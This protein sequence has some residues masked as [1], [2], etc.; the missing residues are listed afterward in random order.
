MT[1]RG[2]THAE[3]GGEALVRR[4]EDDVG[5]ELRLVRHHDQRQLDLCRLDFRRQ[6]RQHGVGSRPERWSLADRGGRA[7]AVVGPAV[8]RA[9]RRRGIGWD[10]QPEAEAARLFSDET[11]RGGRGD[12]QMTA[13]GEQLTANVQL[14]LVPQALGGLVRPLGAVPMSAFGRLPRGQTDKATFVVPSRVTEMLLTL[15]GVG[16]SSATTPWA[17]QSLERDP[18]KV[19]SSVTWTSSSCLY[20]GGPLWAD[21]GGGRSGMPG[22]TWTMMGESRIVVS[23]I[24]FKASAGSG[25]GRATGCRHEH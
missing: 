20:A 14:D 18:A 9:H 1:S 10:D 3:V 2:G 19:S 15:F 25:A 11:R 13:S 6:R 8:E 5:L 17:S 21:S 23:S 22:R 24:R 4:L 7:D 12:G 16:R